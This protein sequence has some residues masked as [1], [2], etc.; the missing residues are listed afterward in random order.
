MMK[1]S[2]SSAFAKPHLTKENAMRKV[3]TENLP[4]LD[5]AQLGQ[6]QALDGLTPDTSDIPEAPQ[7]NWREARRFYRP[8]KQAISIRLYADVLDWLRHKSD[9][10]QVE[11]NRILREK[12]DAEVPGR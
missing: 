7:E 8:I 5:S 10:Y 3:T 9:R 11:I 2:G 1:P 4:P 12:M 6:L